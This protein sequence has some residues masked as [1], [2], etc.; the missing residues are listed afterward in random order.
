MRDANGEPDPDSRSVQ[1]IVADLPHETA[2]SFITPKG[3]RV[4]VMDSR[5]L[6]NARKARESAFKVFTGLLAP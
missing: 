2:F 4:M 3:D 6:S 5:V 1:V